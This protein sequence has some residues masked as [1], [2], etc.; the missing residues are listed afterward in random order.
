LSGQAVSNGVEK[1]ITSPIKTQAPATIP[2]SKVLATGNKYQVAELPTKIDVKAAVAQKRISLEER[3][4]HSVEVGFETDEESSSNGSG[5]AAKLA[6]PQK[7]AVPRETRSAGHDEDQDEIEDEE[8]Y[9]S[10]ID[11]LAEI[12]DQV[13]QSN[14]QIPKQIAPKIVESLTETEN[15]PQPA[16]I[17]ADH[18]STLERGLAKRISKG[19][20]QVSVF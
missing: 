7:M 1:P 19:K 14:G 20:Y 4:W 3:K 2:E 8:E 6:A 10:E 5:K 9:E 11:E 13:A 17:S 15:Q 16:E 12:V 18:L